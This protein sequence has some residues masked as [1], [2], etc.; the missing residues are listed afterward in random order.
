MDLLEIRKQHIS[1]Y[2]WPSSGLILNNAVR[3]LYNYCKRALVLVHTIHTIKYRRCCM[4]HVSLSCYRPVRPK[5]LPCSR[6][7]DLVCRNLV[8]KLRWWIWPSQRLKLHRTSAHPPFEWDSNPLSQ[9]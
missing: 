2:H 7:V 3:V 9:W 4:W 1:A 6:V 5:D 8:G